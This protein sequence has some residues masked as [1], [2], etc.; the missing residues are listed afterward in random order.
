MNMKVAGTLG[1]Y[2]SQ[3]VQV[4]DEEEKKDSP[5]RNS[6][7]KIDESMDSKCESTNTENEVWDKSLFVGL[8][9]K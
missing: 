4:G 2:L 1:G 6:S 8:N 5:S 7:N 9:A 3:R